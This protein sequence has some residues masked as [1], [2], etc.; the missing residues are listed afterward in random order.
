MGQ[1]CCPNSASALHLLKGSSWH[2]A[3]M[4]VLS[5]QV[6][7]EGMNGP[8]SVAVCGPS[9]TPTIRP[10]QCELL[11]RNRPSNAD[12]SIQPCQHRCR[13]PPREYPT[14]PARPA[15]RFMRSPNRRRKE[16]RDGPNA[17][18][19]ASFWNLGKSACYSIGTQA[20]IPFLRRRPH[21]H[22]LS[23]DLRASYC[24]S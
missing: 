3:V 20:Q 24:S 16:V 8:S 22:R 14:L 4:P 1:L 19:A 7:H 10:R 17:P 2:E 15:H 12:F 9:L 11:Q 18:S 23:R 6:R 5:P 21:H 13:I